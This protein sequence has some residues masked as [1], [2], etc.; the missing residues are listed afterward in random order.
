MQK[1]AFPYP[2][3][4]ESGNIAAEPLRD[5]FTP[6]KAFT[7]P[8]FL[9]FTSRQ[10]KRFSPILCLLQLKQF[11]LL[12]SF[13]K[14][15]DHTESGFQQMKSSQVQEE[16]RST[17]TFIDAIVQ[18]QTH[19]AGGGRQR[20]SCDCSPSFKFMQPWEGKPR[21]GAPWRKKVPEPH[22]YSTAPQHS[23]LVEVLTPFSI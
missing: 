11:C 16:P 9:H 13:W 15:H 8:W 5:F 12:Q 19:T 22:A 4:L 2:T 18:N 23:F 3:F 21:H 20:L 6:M 17:W 7:L 14:S 10:G 1:N